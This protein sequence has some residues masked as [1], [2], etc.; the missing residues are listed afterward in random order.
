MICTGI[1]LEP[2]KY[3]TPDGLYFLRNVRNPKKH[4]DGQ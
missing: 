4:I 1:W 3:S 2:K